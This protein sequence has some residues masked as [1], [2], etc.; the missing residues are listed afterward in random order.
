MMSAMGT[1]RPEPAPTC[2]RPFEKLTSSYLISSKGVPSSFLAASKSFRPTAR[3][4]S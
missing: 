3:Q 1:E 4:A 2:I